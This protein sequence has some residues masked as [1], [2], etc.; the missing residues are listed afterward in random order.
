MSLSHFIVIFWS[1][2]YLKAFRIWNFKGIWENWVDRRL[3]WNWNRHG[4]LDVKGRPFLKNLQRNWILYQASLG[5]LDKSLDFRKFLI[6][7]FLFIKKKTWR[8]LSTRRWNTEKGS[9]ALV[10]LLNFVSFLIL[11]ML[12]I[13]TVSWWQTWLITICGGRFTFSAE[14]VL[15]SSLWSIWKV[16]TQKGWFWTLGAVNIIKH[17]TQIV[18]NYCCCFTTRL[19]LL[20]NHQFY[21]NVTG[22]GVLPQ[23]YGA[24]WKQRP[25]SC[26]LYSVLPKLLSWLKN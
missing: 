4:H 25:S 6:W 7:K 11:K 16:K 3:A 19:R 24:A 23:C 13:G 2:L 15:L 22:L 20:Q 9:R 18:Y 1:C 10:V 8:G 5:N 21:R 14:R 17:N 26:E 12:I